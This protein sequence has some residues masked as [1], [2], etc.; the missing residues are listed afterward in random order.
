MTHAPSDY[1]CIFCNFAQGGES[2][3]KKQSDIVY[4]NEKVIAFV[5]PKWWVGNKGHIIVIPRKHFENIY[6]I[7]E[8]Y[9]SEVQVIGK[10]VAIAMKKA[11]ECDGISFRQ[12]NEPAG[13][14]D[15]WHYHL[16]VFPR[17]EGDN[18]YLNDEKTMWADEHQRE[19]YVKKLAPF[20]P[21]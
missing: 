7:D 18:L 6:E 3:H 8:D 19:E 13:G 4:K 9:L 17:Y 5:S 11:Y 14:Q 15:V 1:F 21:K 10:K 20:S 12:H 2:E 16:H